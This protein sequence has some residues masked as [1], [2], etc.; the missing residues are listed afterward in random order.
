MTLHSK[1]LR[2]R[3]Y[4]EGS[5]LRDGWARLALQISLI[6]LILYYWVQHIERN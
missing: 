6:C 4:I 3:Y 5:S 1:V 2:V